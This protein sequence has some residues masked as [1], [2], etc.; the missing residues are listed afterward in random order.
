MLL[1]DK[2]MPTPI[3]DILFKIFSFQFSQNNLFSECENGNPLV[4]TFHDEPSIDAA[5]TP[6]RQQTKI[7]LPAAKVNPLAKNRKKSDFATPPSIALKLNYV[8]E[9]SS[10]SKEEE[11]ADDDDDEIDVPCVAPINHSPP[12]REDFD[13]WIADDTS[14]RRSPEGGEDM[15]ASTSTV[16][17]N[18][19]GGIHSVVPSSDHT[20]ELSGDEKVCIVDDYYY[21]YKKNAHIDI[22][23]VQVVE[24]KPHK[25]KKSKKDKSNKESKEDRDKRR[26]EKKKK[27]RSKEH[28]L[29]EFLNGTPSGPIDAADDAYEAI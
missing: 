16:G 24:K 1:L 18:S 22:F 14:Q 17:F 5:T 3:G 2:S 12:S 20:D 4:A 21:Y 8:N 9:S 26:E 27:R 19:G 28:D 29:E 15:S 6:I 23:L 11:V 7:E 25:S 13:T 10:S